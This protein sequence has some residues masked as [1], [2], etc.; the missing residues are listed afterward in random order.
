MSCEN[1]TIDVR[2]YQYLTRPEKTIHVVSPR[3]RLTILDEEVKEADQQSQ[4][5]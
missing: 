3:K 5:G 2:F 1:V 4:I